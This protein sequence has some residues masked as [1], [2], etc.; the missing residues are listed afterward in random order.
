MNSP[1]LSLSRPALENLAFSLEEGRLGFPVHSFALDPY[2]P[3]NLSSV[4]AT[5]LNKLRQ[6]GMDGKHIAYI[7][8]V[9]AQERAST[10]KWQDQTNLVW[11]G[12]EVPG[13]ESRD[14][15]I[16]VQ[17]LFRS[18]RHSVL[19]ASYALDSGQKGYSLFQALADQMDANPELNVRMFLNV[20]RAYQSQT[21][22]SEL[23]KIFAN[24]FR[25]KV[26]PGK[27]LPEVFHDPRA[28]AISNYSLAC[29]HAKCVVV[30]EE[31]LLIT[32][33]NFTEAAHERNIEAGIL[34][35][36]AFIARSI[37]SQFERLV[38][39]GILCRVPGL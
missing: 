13:A 16:V 26:W 30:D 23:L 36:D 29:L 12:P 9:L 17:E 1:F 2:L 4:I 27:R 37:R 7:L 39:K 5:E 38:E 10:Q 35:A 24:T 22:A 34:M 25:D 28:L 14:T 21:P 32:S 6:E 33:A 8:R 31:R 15:H 20:K 11:T 3:E 18:A 19:I